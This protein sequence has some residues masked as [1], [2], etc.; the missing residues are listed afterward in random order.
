MRFQEDHA[1]QRTHP[2]PR[3]SLRP[4]GAHEPPSL[5]GDRR[6]LHIDTLTSQ[7]RGW[8]APRAILCVVSTPTGRTLVERTSCNPFG[9]RDRTAAIEIRKQPEG[10]TR[11]PRANHN[12]RKTSTMGVPRASGPRGE[13]PKPRES[14]RRRREQGTSTRGVQRATAGSEGDYIVLVNPS[15]ARMNEHEG[16]RTTVARHLAA[17][18]A[19][20]SLIR[21]RSVR[22]SLL[23]FVRRR[24]DEHEG[25]RT[26][27]HRIR[28][29]TL[30][31]G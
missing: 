14:E 1:S 18:G 15:E 28:S 25:I 23:A 17:L 8:Q 21:I 26:P 2:R 11:I 29:P 4:G 7:Q 12:P 13:R 6:T 20:C 16:I 31:P 27:D 9:E 24:I 19:A 30:Y 3:F 22:D 10:R 5:E